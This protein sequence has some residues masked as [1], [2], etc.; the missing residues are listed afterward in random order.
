ML[1]AGHSLGGTLAAILAALHPARTRG[2]VL[3]EAPLRFGVGAGALGTLVAA[4]PWGPE[5]ARD[6]LGVVPGS[7]ISA[8][9]VAA[10]PIE[11]LPARWLDALGSAGDPEAAATHARVLRW[12]LDELAMPGQL[13]ADIAGR[14][15]RDDAFHRGVIQVAGRQLGP[16]QLAIPVLA[17]VDPLSRLVPPR[18]TIPFLERTRGAW[19][20]L[21]H[22][23]ED[24]GIA[25]RHVGPLVGRKAHRDLW[26]EI[27]RWANAVS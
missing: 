16:E 27:L 14:L 20:V 2:L 10:D 25:L 19:T 24:A 15:C 4:T 6:I 9:G 7:M 21:Q 5:A 23:D 26:P 8:L 17:V 12:T 18:S 22:R 1:L 11:F 13:F 3:V